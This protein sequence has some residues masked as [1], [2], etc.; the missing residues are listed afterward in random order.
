MTKQF[1]A[2]TPA[3]MELLLDVLRAILNGAVPDRDERVL[4]PTVYSVA[5]SLI[6]RARAVLA[7]VANP[8]T[9]LL[10]TNGDPTTAVPA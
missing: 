5:P 8:N 4:E 6:L 3:N 10:D 9:P 7:T 2:A 1:L